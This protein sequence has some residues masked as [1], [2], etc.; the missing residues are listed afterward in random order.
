MNCIQAGLRCFTS[1]KEHRTRC[2][3]V[4]TIKLRKKKVL[5]YASIYKIKIGKENNTEK[6]FKSEGTAT[7]TFVV[8]CSLE[9]REGWR[10]PVENC[11]LAGN[12]VTKLGTSDNQ[13]I[14][15]I[16]LGAGQTSVKNTVAFR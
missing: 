7:N 15:S 14:C 3:S 16:V 13:K 8:G 11:T 5:F 2:V 4:I 6:H 1:Y 10:T 12:A 9:M